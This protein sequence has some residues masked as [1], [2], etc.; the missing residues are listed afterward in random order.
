MKQCSFTSVWDSGSEI[1]TPA[2]LDRYLN[3]A[4]AVYTLGNTQISLLKESIAK[5][6]IE[7][8][9]DTVMKIRDKLIELLRKVHEFDTYAHSITEQ[10]ATKEAKNNLAMLKKTFDALLYKLR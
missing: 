6:E 7:G 10:R 4:Q 1:T 2:I 5:G 9:H 3:Q 8:P